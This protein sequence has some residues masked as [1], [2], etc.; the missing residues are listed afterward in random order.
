MKS[1]DRDAVTALRTTLAAIDNAEAVETTGPHAP[2]TSGN[3]AEAGTGAGSTEVPRRELTTRDVRAI[4]R[5]QV[6]D[7]I[8][9]AAAYDAH[10]QTHAA[11]R[12]RRE[13]ATL[14]RYIEP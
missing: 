8:T 12:L 10:G 13:A 3:T 11:D 5:A 6:A 14:A 4:L 2:H 1:R 7:R 9:G